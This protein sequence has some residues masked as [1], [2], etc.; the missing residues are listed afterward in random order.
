MR[1]KFFRTAGAILAAGVLVFA[2]ASAQAATITIVNNN[3]AGVGFNDPTP[4]APVGGN[5][6][7]TLGAQRLFVFQHAAS[8]WGSIL[9]SN[10]Q[11]LVRAQFA[12]QT[13]NATSA[14]LGSAGPITIHRDFVNAP[15]AATWYHQSLANRL[16]ESDLSPTNPDITSTFNLNIDS[17]CFGP[18]LLWYYGIDGNEGVNIE[19][20]PVVLHELGH[21][22]GFS[23]TT[24][25]TTGNF[26]S[27]FP[28]VYDRYLL[29]NTLGLHWNEMSAAQRVASAIALDHLVWDGPAAVSAA[30]GYL[31][32]RPILTVN[33]PGSIAGVKTAQLASFGAQAFSLTGNVVLVDD[34]TPDNAD[35]CEPIVNGGALAGNIAL[36]NRGT[37]TFVAKCAAAQAAGAIGVLIANNVSPGPAP[38]GGTDPSITIPCMGLTLADGTAIQNEL[39]NGPVNVT[40]GFSNTLKAGADTAGR[41]LMYTPSPFQGGSS[42][43]HWDTSMMPN[44]LMEPAITASLH[45][46]VDLTLGHFTDIGWFQGT[47]PVVLQD[48]VAEG[49]GDGIALRWRFEDPS[50]VGAITVERAGAVE[51]PWAAAG[52]DISREGSHM[53]ALDVTAEPGVTLHYRLRVMDRSGEVTLMG[54]ASAKRTI[55]SSLRTALGAPVPNPATAGTSVSYRVAAAQDV[56]LTVHDVSGRQV[57]TLVD[58]RVAAGDHVQQWD[59]RTDSGAE[60]SAGVYFIQMRSTSGVKT[61]RVTIVR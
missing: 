13:C 40:M 39:L 44:A 15:F 18:G 16:A 6:G 2:L 32:A 52:I 61:Q 24:S 48:F 47:V 31:G 7:V 34:G 55:E 49:R 33:S 11:I 10:V 38:M 53:V 58:G 8:I 35:A 45:D 5:P 9:P 25:G 21:G 12:A 51:G 37:C 60:A 42:V 17:G 23:T 30:A 22:L 1:N 3:A 54:M 50:E 46:A 28:S 29:D 26:N 27:G 57:R 19:L 4:R 56:K 59:G 41:P 36:I 20:L 14:V 43:S